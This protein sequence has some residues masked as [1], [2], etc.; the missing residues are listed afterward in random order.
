MKK[1]II[2]EV[3]STTTK[4]YLY[5]NNTI[6]ELDMVVIP[7]KADYKKDNRINEYNKKM[8]FNF[9][10]SIKEKNI[11]VYGTS[12]FRNLNNIERESWIKEFKYNTGFDFMVVT[13]DMENEYTVYG[14]INDIDY[15]AKIAIM[16]G[17]GGS[18]ELSIVENGK[19]IEKANSSFGAIDIVESYPDLKEDKATTD[20]DFMIN[21]TKKLVNVPK[22]K[23]DLLVL[24]GGNYIYFYEELKYPIEKNKFYKDVLQP[25]CIDRESMDIFDKKFFYDMS[26]DEIGKR[27]NK[28]SWWR[29]TRGMRICVE[30]L[31]QVLDAK[32]IIPTKINMVYGI[33]E[34]LKN[35]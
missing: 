31:V 7:F 16:I 21:E 3:G 30:A 5:E 32:Y 10:K 14:V 27:T 24:A 11:F 19:I 26:L 33:A 23:A 20:Y 17:G 2:V 4:S 13:P 8:L 12:I 25:Y 18:T 29:G 6:K 9:I 1:F 34:I 28:D 22:N 15:D 35:K